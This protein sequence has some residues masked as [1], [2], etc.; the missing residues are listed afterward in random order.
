MVN[1]TNLVYICHACENMNIININIFSFSG[2]RT[3][4]IECACGH[5]K[6]TLIKNSNNSVKAE[7]ICP[8]C[9]EEHSFVIPSNQFWTKEAYTFPCPNYEATALIVG[10]ADK[11]KAPITECLLNEYEPVEDEDINPVNMQKVAAFF[12]D[13]EDNP[14][15]YCFCDCNAGYTAAYNPENLYIICKKCGYSKKISY[16]EVYNESF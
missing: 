8:A 6:I 7:L 2:N 10:S 1:Q 3:R 5:S 11:L 15:K 13:V 4:T 9:K 16:D 12:R 14:D